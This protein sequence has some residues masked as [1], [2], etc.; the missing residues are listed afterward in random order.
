MFSFFPSE[1][2]SFDKGDI[3]SAECSMTYPFAT[4]IPGNN[5]GLSLSRRFEDFLVIEL[6]VAAESKGLRFWWTSYQWSRQQ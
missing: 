2:T 1:D 3:P 4:I 5:V 6:P